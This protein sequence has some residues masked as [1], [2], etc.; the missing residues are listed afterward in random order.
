MPQANYPLDSGFF[1]LL[2]NIQTRLAALETQQ[3]YQI[4]DPSNG[5]PII[6]LGVFPGSPITAGYQVLDSDG[7]VIVQTGTN[8]GGQYGTFI[9]DTSGNLRAELGLLSNGDF[10]ALVSDPTLGVMSEI[11][12]VYESPEVATEQYTTSTTYTDLATAGP[13]VTATIGALGTALVNVNSYIATPGAASA[14]NSRCVGVSIDGGAPTG[15]LDD[16]LIASISTPVG[17]AVGIAVNQSAQAYISG[18]SPGQHTF[19]M[20]YRSNGSGGNCGFASRFLQVRPL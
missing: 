7:N 16:I 10:G 5:Q 14:V 18:L 6:T 1:I 20:K 12:P 17:A 2:K 19:E 13:S 3:Q 9:Y 4:A 8:S 15:V 11:L